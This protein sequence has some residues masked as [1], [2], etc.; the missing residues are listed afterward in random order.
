VRDVAPQSGDLAMNPNPH[1]MDEPSD[2]SILAGLHRRM[3]GVEPLVAPPPAWRGDAS[4]AYPGSRMTVRSKIAFGGLVPLVLIAAIVTVAVGAGLAGRS[5]SGVSGSPDPNSTLVYQL[6]APSGQ[7]ITDTD[8]EKT[9]SIL[10]NRLQAAG[11]AA[12]VEKMPT[13]EVVVGVI[14]TTELASIAAT[15]EA[16]GKLEFVLLPP[17]LYGTAAGPGSVEIPASGATIDPALPAQFTGADLDLAQ[18]SAAADPTAPGDWLVHFAF[19]GDAASRFETWSGQHVNDYFAIVLDGVVESAPYIESKVVGGAGQISGSFTEADAERLASVIK[20]G[21]LPFPLIRAISLPTVTVPTDIPS[22]GRTLGNPDASVAVDVWSDY[23]CP[24]CRAFAT[25]VLPELLGKGVRVGLV[26][27][28]YHD[29]I[30]VDANV[31]SHDSAN[32]AN[33]AR[34]AADQSKFWAYQD[35]LWANQGTEGDGAF[36][37]ARLVAIGAR[38]GLDNDAFSTCVQNGSMASEVLAESTA[39]Q[40]QGIN[41][42][43][44]V[45]VNGHVLAASDNAT[46][47]AAI[48]SSLP[49]STPSMESSQ[50][51]ASSASPANS[52]SPSPSQSAASTASALRSPQTATPIP[53]A[54]ASPAHSAPA[55]P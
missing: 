43:P 28:V 51:P 4:S 48:D 26:K 40:A 42:T 50:S 35:W 7:S 18:V 44:T 37:T 6:V 10:Q 31:G 8:L 2:E 9:V 22:N 46:I 23:Q 54:S 12:T 55:S 25:E 19:S 13:D 38:V 47:A 39:G 49:V 32:A 33:A 30:V 15:V 45:V 17:D 53:A 29:R 34:C 1:D 41:G 27:I 20:N 24:Q 3:S 21:Q 16:M 36:T 52:G 5:R 11:L 14:D